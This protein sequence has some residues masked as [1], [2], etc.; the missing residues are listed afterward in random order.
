MRTRPRKK[1]FFAKRIKELRK[2]AGFTQSMLAA[3]SGLGI[4]T[5]RLF[6]YG[7]R[8]PAYGTLLK[9][10]GGLGISLAAFDQPKT[11]K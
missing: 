10:A 9:L 11:K 4:S 5:V 3:K 7:L 8:E 2:Q 6:E 1:S